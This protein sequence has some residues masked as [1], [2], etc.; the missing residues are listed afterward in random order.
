MAGALSFFTGSGFAEGDAIDGD[1]SAELLDEG[2]L[3]LE[4]AIAM[5]VTTDPHRPP[6]NDFFSSLLGSIES[7]Q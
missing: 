4:R 3:D 2:Q 6:R 1:G 5:T 7:A